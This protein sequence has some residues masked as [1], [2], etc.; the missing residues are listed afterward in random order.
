MYIYYLVV[1]EVGA[2]KYSLANNIFLKQ[3][4]IFINFL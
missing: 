3:L 2:Y 1:L 4:Y